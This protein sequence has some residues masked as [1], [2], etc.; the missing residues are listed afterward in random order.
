GVRARV[1]PA[2][3]VRE[4]VLQ[5]GRGARADHDR[6]CEPAPEGAILPRARADLGEAPPEYRAEVAGLH[7]VRDRG[8]RVDGPA[9][10]AHGL[11][12]LRLE[13][14][15][16][17]ARGHDGHALPAELASHDSGKGR[18]DRAV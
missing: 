6:A 12:H 3:L 15:G 7:R 13:V 14:L 17:L 16:E 8:D 2:E 18:L 4:A 5:I 11:P 9:G 10:V 1:V